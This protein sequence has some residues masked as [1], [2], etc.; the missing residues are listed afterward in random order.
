MRLCLRNSC[1]RLSGDLFRQVEILERELL[2]HEIFENEGGVLIVAACGNGALR[3]CRRAQQLEL[4]QERL[5]CQAHFLECKCL[6][7]EVLENGH[8]IHVAAACSRKPMR[9]C[10]RK[11]NLEL[12][13]ELRFP[14]EILDRKLLRHEVL[15]K[16]KRVCIASACG[17]RALRSCKRKQQLELVRRSC[18]AKHSF[19]SVNSSGMKYSRTRTASLPPPLVAI[20]PCGYA[21]EITSSSLRRSFLFA[22]HS[23][24]SVQNPWV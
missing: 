17:P 19:S 8:G 5:F 1:S 9:S 21:G 6:G 14:A 11:H 23:F 22:K 15:E 16:K 12:A 7:H 24:P 2:G 18:S 4:A 20:G 10:W 3:L 13:Q